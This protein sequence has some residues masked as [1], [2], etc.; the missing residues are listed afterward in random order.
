MRAMSCSRAVRAAAN[1][2]HRAGGKREGGEEGEEQENRRDEGV[3]VNVTHAEAARHM[4]RRYALHPRP[5]PR[6]PQAARNSHA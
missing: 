5:R 3:I 2:M 6:I 4:D 1:V